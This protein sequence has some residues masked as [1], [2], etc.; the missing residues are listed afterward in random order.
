MQG[1]NLLD[2]KA[3]AAREAVFGAVYTHDAVDIH[4]PARSLQWR[5]CVSGRWKLCVPNP[6]AVPDAKAEL[7]DLKA[8][9]H[10]KDN[11]AAEHADEVARLRRLIDAWYKPA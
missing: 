10:E 7:Y 3:L 4:K 6:A 8:D 5:W 2:A 11:V 1:V 9:P